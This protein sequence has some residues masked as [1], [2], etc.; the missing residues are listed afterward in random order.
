M[1]INLGI[2]PNIGGMPPSLNIIIIN[3]NFDSIFKFLILLL[4]ERDLE[5]ETLNIII[6]R[7]VIIIYTRK[8]SKDKKFDKGI[9]IIIH[10]K[11]EIE[12]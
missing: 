9:E 12:E 7:E 11:W 6:K 10:P 8:Y 4:L 3:R 5:E 2:N 1:V